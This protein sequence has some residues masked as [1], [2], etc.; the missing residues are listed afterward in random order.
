ME[1]KITHIPE[2]QRFETVVDAFTGFVTYEVA[3]GE[4]NIDHTIVPPPIE[5]RGI[6]AALVRKAYDYALENG[7]KCCATCSYA[8]VWLRRHPEYLR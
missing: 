8:D 6:A 7:L 2:K 1:Y 3:N 4:L 5:G